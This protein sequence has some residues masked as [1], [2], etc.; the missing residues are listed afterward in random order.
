M[1][2]SIIHLEVAYRLL[3]KW[4]WIKNP[5]D[6][7]V[8]AVAPDA[9]HFCENYQ[10]QMKEKSHIWDCGPRWGITEDSNKWESNVMRFWE[11]N[12]GADNRD[13]IAGYCVHILTDIQNDIKI[14]RPFRQMNT[15]GM[16]VEE[17]YYIYGKEARESDQWLYQTSLHSEHIMELLAGGRAYSIADC[18]GQGE[19][20]KLIQYML[21]EEYVKKEI[22]DISGFQYCNDKVIL[23]FIEE[24]TE[25]L[26]ERMK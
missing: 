25:W 22:Y 20:N 3:A 13:F 7:L 6:F 9:V 14:W 18:I 2:Y 21:T 16:T 5:G 8:G 23:G 4:D 24:C 15:V 17:V 12:K 1:A 26:A 11:E 10:I 19:I